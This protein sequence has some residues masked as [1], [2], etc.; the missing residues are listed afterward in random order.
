[1]PIADAFI[2]WGHS[3]PTAQPS[4]NPSF[5]RFHVYS[6]MGTLILLV[7]VWI[8]VKPNKRDSVRSLRVDW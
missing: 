6:F 4:S 8:L 2:A 3:T 1:L 7:F 5:A